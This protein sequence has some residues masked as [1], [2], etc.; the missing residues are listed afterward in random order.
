M[1]NAKVLLGGVRRSTSLYYGLLDRFCEARW[2]PFDED[3]LQLA[4]SMAGNTTGDGT[5]VRAAPDCGCCA[6]HGSAVR[7]YK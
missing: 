1:S 4:A 3:Q 5:A 6:S 2:G 7:V